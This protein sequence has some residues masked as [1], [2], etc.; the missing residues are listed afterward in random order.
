MKRKIRK[1]L[2]EIAGGD[3]TAPDGFFLDGAVREFP[4]PEGIPSISIMVEELQ[5]MTDVLLGRQR[6]PIN[7]GIATLMEVADAYFG[8]ASEMTIMI[9]ALEREG[10]VRRGDALYKFRTG[11]LR[12]FMDMSKRMCET[13]SRRITTQQI[14]QDAMRRG[15][16]A[17]GYD[18]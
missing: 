15:L 10:K 17:E 8:R 1:S 11:E 16:E 12:T 18:E 13:G 2:V 7:E 9:L 5:D 3:E 6:S 14:H 4:I